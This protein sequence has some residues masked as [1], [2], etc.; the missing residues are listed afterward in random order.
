MIKWKNA[1]TYIGVLVFLGLSVSCAGPANDTMGAIQMNILQIRWQRL[2]DEKGRTCDRCSSTEKAM[3]V[4]IQKLQRSLKE[5]DIHVVL[6]KE[7][8]NPSAFSKDPLQSNRIWIAGK[9]H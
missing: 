3:E 2:V 6:E 4:A 7:A 8:L 1:A 9:I 5:L